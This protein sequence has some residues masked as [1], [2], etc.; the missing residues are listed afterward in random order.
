MLVRQ[1]SIRSGAAERGG[2][3]VSMLLVAAVLATVSAGAL[4][5]ALSGQK[6]RRGAQEDLHARYVCQAGLSNA[7]FDVQRGQTGNLGSEQNPVDWEGAR[8]Y[9]QR[10]D[11]AGGLIQLRATGVEDRAGARME[12][13]MREVPATSYRYG[14]FGKEY[15]HLDSNAKVDSYDS[16][17]GTYATQAVN[18]SGADQH[19]RIEGDIGSNGP[20]TIEQNA[21]V[22]GDAPSG[23]SQTTT[24]MGNAVVTGA[25]TPATSLQTLPTLTVPTLPSLGN[26]NVSSSTTWATGDRRYGTLQVNSNKTLTITGPA[27]IVCTN[28]ALSSNSN[29]I[30]DATN[31]P[32]TLYVI[33][34]FTMSQ[35]AVMRSTTYDPHALA[36]NLLSDNVF[37]PETNVTVDSVDMLSNTKLYGTMVAPNARIVINSNFELFGSLVARS[38]DLHSNSFL[39]FDESLNVLAAAGV[40]DWEILS[41]RSMP[42]THDAP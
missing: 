10:T 35:N 42:Y 3:L 37:N 23:P 1:H 39:H 19:A 16:T 11:V 17:L 12:L 24:V 29:F 38:V 31:G 4:S 33:D 15:F 34:N 40:P 27:T 30:V 18:G 26:L 9:V 14:A 36:V 21:K 22:W 2:A 8:F 25:T 28:F 41:W 5:M 13:V 7:V 6:E 20:I 32:V